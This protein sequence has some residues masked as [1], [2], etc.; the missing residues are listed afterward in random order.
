[1]TSSEPQ[2]YVVD[3]AHRDAF[4]TVRSEV[5]MRGDRDP[6]PDWELPVTRIV[7]MLDGQGASITSHWD[8]R[9]SRG[10]GVVRCGGVAG[11]GVRPMFRHRKI[12]SAMMRWQLRQM[13][14]QGYHAASLYAFREAFYRRFGYELT[15]ARW[16]VRVPESRMPQ[17][18]MELEPRVIAPEALEELDPC[19]LAFARAHAGVNY[20]TPRHWQHRMGQRAPMI[21]A[22][23]DPVEA[24]CWT[25]M[26]GGF[27][28]ELSFGEVVWSTMRGYRSMLAFMRGLVIN[29]KAAIWSEPSEGP[30]LT[31]YMDQGIQVE[32]HRPAM[33]RIVNVPEAIRQLC[34]EESGEFSLAVHDADLPENNGPWRVRFRAGEAPEVDR[35][36]TPDLDLDIRPFS[37]AFFGE[38]SLARLL[39]L[40]IAFGS[41]PQAALR[42][43][44]PMPTITTEFF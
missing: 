40:G 32:L 20:R 13:R 9:L 6:L 1:M 27:W 39:D 43:F 16:Q 22:F 11:V 28:D 4:L 18:R 10:E 41:N 17:T 3:D 34:P 30:M 42:L 25:S 33:S 26:E 29:R 38:P 35:G 2:F 31:Q 23:G 44:T 37:Q 24:Y 19:Y 12:G 5:Y 7:G 8:F 36:G 21:Y 15:G 14:E